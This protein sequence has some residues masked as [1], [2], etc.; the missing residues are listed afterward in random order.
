MFQNI[1][2][3]GVLVYDSVSLPVFGIAI[4]EFTV[5]CKGSYEISKE[6]VNDVPVYHIR[7]MLHWILSGG[8]QPIQTESLAFSVSEIPADIFAEI[9]SRVKARYI[10]T[11]DI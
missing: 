4:N 5:T 3:M 9:Y 7:T 6:V 8:S 11:A 10:S 1:H 2:Q